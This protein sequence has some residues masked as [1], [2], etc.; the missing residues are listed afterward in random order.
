MEEVR[1]VCV[2][3]GLMKQVEGEASASQGRRGRLPGLR[4]RLSPAG[5]PTQVVIPSPARPLPLPQKQIKSSLFPTN[6]GSGA[7]LSGNAET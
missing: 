5:L 2:A 7:Q 6:A 4:P 1:W 3:N